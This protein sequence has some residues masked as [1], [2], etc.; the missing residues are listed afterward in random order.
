MRRYITPI[1]LAIS[2]M[3]L[4]GCFSDEDSP[5]VNDDGD[6]DTS[7]PEGLE[8]TGFVKQTLEIEESRDPRTVNGVDFRFTDLDNPDAYDDVL[9]DG[10]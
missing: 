6:G 9:D 2:V 7:Q 10:T 3:G 8:F 5:E 4:S 1:I